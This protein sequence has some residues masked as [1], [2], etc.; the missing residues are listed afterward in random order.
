MSYTLTEK[1]LLA[2][3]PRVFTADATVHGVITILDTAPFKVKQKVVIKATG[4]PNQTLEVKRVLSRTQL[5]VGP[6]KKPI[7]VFSDLSL[8]TT[9]K[10]STI[11]AN[12]DLRPTI[13][14]QEIERLTYEEEPTIARRVVIVDKYGDK[15][16]EDNPITAKQ[17]P[18]SEAVYNSIN[19]TNTATPL[20]V[21][22]TNL[23][24]RS[25][26]VVQ[27]KGST[28]FVGYDNTVTSGNNGTG[29]K[30]TSNSVMVFI[31]DDGVT[32]YGI[33]T[34][35]GSVSTFVSEEKS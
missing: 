26:V 4:E 34:G 28:I 12:E 33:K 30:V 25:Q 6:V 16:D 9:A 29:I 35:G 5:Q 31:I 23:E 7:H 14:E 2:I 1:R 10:A 20:R 3:L 32:L 13:P 11:E 18:T 27:P 8:Y 17:K 15:F 19:V 21:G 22:A 24:G